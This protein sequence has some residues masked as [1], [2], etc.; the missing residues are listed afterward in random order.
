VS[1]EVEVQKVG[2]KDDQ[3]EQDVKTLSRSK[4]DDEGEGIHREV[5]EG[6]L[7]AVMLLELGM[8]GHVDGV[9]GND[10]EGHEEG[11][12]G[13]DGIGCCHGCIAGRAK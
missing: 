5:R 2:Q 8:L 6:M 4:D 1:N 10:V 3:L 12:I 9:V 13:Q 11:G 7:N